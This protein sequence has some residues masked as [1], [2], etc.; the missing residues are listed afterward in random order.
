MRDLLDRKDFDDTEVPRSQE[1]AP[2]QDPTVGLCLGPCGG[3]KG[4]GCSYER[5]TRVLISKVTFINVTT[6]GKT[7]NLYQFRD[8][9]K[10]RQREN[11]IKTNTGGN[12]QKVTF[13]DTTM[14]VKYAPAIL[15]WV[16]LMNTCKCTPACNTPL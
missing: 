11:F 15:N 4:G 13:I 14:A 3:P 2:P 7:K 1:I 8:I 16:P 12:R 10:T 5:G 6:R 9:A